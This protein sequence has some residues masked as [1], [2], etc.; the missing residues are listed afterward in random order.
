MTRHLYRAGTASVLVAGLVAVLLT[1]AAP[2]SDKP[3]GRILK[4]VGYSA[5]IRRASYG[6][7]H[8]TAAN[9]ASLG[10]GAGYVQAEDN[11]CTIAEKIVTVDA[12]RSRYFGASDANVSSD[13]FYQ[14]AKE[15]GVVE[16]LLA[17][18]PDGVRAPSQQARDLMRWFAAGYSNYLRKTG[19]ANLTDPTCSGKPW[20]RQIDAL[21]LWRTNWASVVRHGSG[22]LLD[23]IV[24]A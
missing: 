23:G 10:F 3:T 22:T 2:A 5:E 19:V 6:V 9:F 16:R 7:P 15:D 18:T 14:K 11:V 13:L 20:V 4:V 17:G 1:G 21:D 12:T 8:I 24:G